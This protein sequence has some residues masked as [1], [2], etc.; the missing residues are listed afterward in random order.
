MSIESDEIVDKLLQKID[1]LTRESERRD[2][3]AD[4]AELQTRRLRDELTEA[5][6]KLAAGAVAAAKAEAAERAH[7]MLWKAAK[8]F[9]TDLQGIPFKIAEIDAATLNPSRQQL[10]Q[11][12][13][14]SEDFVDQIPF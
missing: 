11:A 7:E 8:K 3:R 9:V 6:R 1:E 10:E 14:A 2:S 13:K 12:L 4:D 5:N